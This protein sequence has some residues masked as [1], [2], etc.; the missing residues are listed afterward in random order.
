MPRGGGCWGGHANTQ[1]DVTS[2]R[3][4][5]IGTQK[6]FLSPL[7]GQ[8]FKMV[9]GPVIRQEVKMAEVKAAI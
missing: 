4:E 6:F 2:A 8:E 9:D 3:S 1:S 7:I 5:H